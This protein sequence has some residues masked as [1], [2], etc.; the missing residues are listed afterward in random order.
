MQT[1]YVSNID[2]VGQRG[3]VRGGVAQRVLA[4]SCRSLFY[5][6]T[7]GRRI[8]RIILPA[9]PGQDFIA[10]LQAN[11]GPL[12]EVCIAAVNPDDLWIA[13]HLDPVWLRDCAVDS[14]IDDPDLTA[15]VQRAG[16]QMLTANRPEVIRRVNHKGAFKALF[17][18]LVQTVPGEVGQGVEEVAALVAAR[19][20]CF[21]RM[22][23]AGG[24]VGNLVFRTPVSAAEAARQ[25]LEANSLWAGADGLVEP[26]LD[27]R[28][29]PGVAFEIGRN[30]P[31]YSF[32][33]ITR[34]GCEYVGCWM[35][36]PAGVIAR[37]DLDRIGGAIIA[38]LSETG[39][40]GEADVDLGVTD[41]GEVYGFEINGRKDGVRHVWEAVSRWHGRDE[42]Q[43]RCAVKAV[44]TFHLRDAGLTTRALLDRLGNAGLLAQASSPYGVILSIPPRQ[45]LAGVILIGKDSAEAQR[46]FLALN[47]LIGTVDNLEEDQPLFP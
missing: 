20:P 45:G 39:F 25:M 46:R 24:G 40:R 41:T 36:A 11:F 14:Y 27:L 28:F 3:H 32:L 7:M 18:G 42:R 23:L 35:P 29:S 30:L 26:I 17:Q 37:D 21:L 8:D 6:Q 19:A 15:C 13:D 1:V 5:T 33:Q 47:D 12:P 2:A 43:W 38:R 16:G 4:I 22:A 31:L 9:D 34:R 10:Y 44:D